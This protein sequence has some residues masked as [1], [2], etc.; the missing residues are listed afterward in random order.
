MKKDNSCLTT[1]KCISVFKGKLKIYTDYFYS[2]KNI[3]NN[4]ETYELLRLNYGSEKITKQKTWSKKISTRKITSA[5]VFIRRKW[6]TEICST[7][8]HSMNTFELDLKNYI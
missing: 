3:N 6:T 1:R 2:L 5:T 8:S 4:V 7:N